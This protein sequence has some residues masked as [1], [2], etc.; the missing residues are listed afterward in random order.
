ELRFAYEAGPCGY[1]IYRYLTKNDMDCVV[2]APSKIPQ[3]SGNRLKNDRQVDEGSFQLVGHD[4][5]A[6]CCSADCFSRIY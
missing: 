6:T 1:G 2:V 5:N 4:N 3:P